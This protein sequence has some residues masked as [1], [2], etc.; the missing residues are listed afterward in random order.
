MLRITLK[1]QQFVVTH[2][3][4]IFKGDIK[5]T[6][7]FLNRPTFKHVTFLRKKY[8]DNFL[9]TQHCHRMCAGNPSV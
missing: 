1:K 6:G 5:K 7:Q 4:T 9:R 3:Y 2:R 8:K